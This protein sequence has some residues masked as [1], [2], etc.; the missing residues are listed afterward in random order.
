MK[1]TLKVKKM[2]S[3]FNNQSKVTFRNYWSY[4]ISALRQKNKVARKSW[5]K[6]KYLESTNGVDVIYHGVTMTVEDYDADDWQ[7]YVPIITLGDIK[8]GQKFKCKKY[9]GNSVFIKTDIPNYLMSDSFQ[10]YHPYINI[11]TGEFWHSHPH[12]L[13]EI[14]IELV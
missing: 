7:I 4:A 8:A 3:N 14:V 5:G 12:N 13:H 11:E 9:H 10:G 2:N 1:F 6:G